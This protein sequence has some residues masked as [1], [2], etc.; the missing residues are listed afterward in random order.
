MCASVCVYVCVHVFT[1]VRSLVYAI[2][3]LNA[4]GAPMCGRMRACV[5]VAT[6]VTRVSVSPSGY[7]LLWGAA[8]LLSS[9]PKRSRSGPARPALL[10][11]GQLASLPAHNIGSAAMCVGITGVMIAFIKS[12]A[13]AA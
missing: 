7:G 5:C 13:R 2:I 10:P 12:R 9:C 6:R 11:A 4:R 8:V 3:L 1:C